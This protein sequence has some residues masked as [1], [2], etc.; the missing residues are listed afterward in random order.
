MEHD[1]A[2]RGTA[3]PFVAE[4]GARDVVTET[5]EGVPLMGATPCIRMQAKPMGTD[6]TLGL[7]Y[8]W[9]RE[10]Q[11]GVFTRQHFLSRPGSKVNA[12]GASG[13]V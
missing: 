6:T 12:V 5:F 13:C 7:R 3:Q 10:A 8:L 11:L 2:G 9:A 1:P 4:C